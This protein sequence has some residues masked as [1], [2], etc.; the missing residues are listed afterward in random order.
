MNINK[1]I[2]AGLAVFFSIPV[3]SQ[4]NAA[5][6]SIVV[7]VK[8]KELS[9]KRDNLIKQIKVEDAKRDMSINGVTF[10]T[11]ERLNDRQDSICLD[12]RSQLVSVE[13]EIKELQPMGNV[14]SVISRS[15]ESLNIDAK[16]EE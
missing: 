10:E 7:S 2:I 14:R 15:M 12:L 11:Q 3:F 5:N 8:L 13:L 16:L 1:I 6:D 4:N 9:L